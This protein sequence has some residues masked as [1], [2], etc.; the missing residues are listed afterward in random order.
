MADNSQS[1]T[2]I[3]S[4]FNMRS[5]DII[6]QDW[7]YALTMISG[8]TTRKLYAIAIFNILMGIAIIGIDIGLMAN[9]DIV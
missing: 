3:S 6:Q 9:D 8:G 1:T 7:K 5:G 2:L 4:D